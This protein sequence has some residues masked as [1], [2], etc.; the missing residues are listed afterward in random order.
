MIQFERKECENLKRQILQDII[1]DKRQNQGFSN[2][3]AFSR[4]MLNNM[5]DET[6]AKQMFVCCSVS[7]T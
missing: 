1:R 6:R 4:S 2:R 5:F 7:P 3:E